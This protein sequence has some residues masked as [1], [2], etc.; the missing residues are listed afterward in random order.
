MDKNPEKNDTK[1][2]KSYLFRNFD[3][4]G[5]IVLRN[6]ELIYD[7]GSM[8]LDDCTEDHSGWNPL[9][10]AMGSLCELSQANPESR[11]FTLENKK[12]IITSST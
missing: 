7:D 9:I 1:N 3:K 8:C 10:F 4:K 5:S 12:W 2:C 11:D 6:I